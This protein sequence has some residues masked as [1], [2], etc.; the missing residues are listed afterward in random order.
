MDASV[1]ISLLGLSFR[2][3]IIGSILTQTGISFWVSISIA[4]ILAEDEG[5]LGSSFLEISSFSVVMLIATIEVVLL[6]MSMSLVTMLD[7][8]M[9]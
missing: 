2:N 4:F 7:L 9:I 1:S 3:G 8:V 5:A 6:K